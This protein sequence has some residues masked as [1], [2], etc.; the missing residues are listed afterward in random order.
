MADIKETPAFEDFARC[1]CP[2]HHCAILKTRLSD[3]D[4]VLKAGADGINEFA[5]R[6]GPV[7]LG[8]L[9]VTPEQMD[10]AKERS[11]VVTW[12]AEFFQPGL[13]AL[14]NPRLCE[15]FPIAN[16]LASQPT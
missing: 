4:E 10:P 14:T 9:C 6:E 2:G 1:D 11:A 8:P 13:D 5:E 12:R 16:I 7:T 15:V 3:S